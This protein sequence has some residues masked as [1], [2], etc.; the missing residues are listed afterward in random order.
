MAGEVAR[1][2]LRIK[3][4]NMDCGNAAEMAAFWGR[5]LGWDI[6]YRDGG[7]VL[8]RDPAGG[9]GVS[10]QERPDYTAPTWPEEEGLQQKMLHL[11]IQVEDAQAAADFAIACGARLAAF[12]GRADLRVMLDPAGHPFCLFTV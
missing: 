8:L 6:T 1:P 3:T 2:K 12:Q 11:E 5:F 10:F 4:V 7:F 9:T